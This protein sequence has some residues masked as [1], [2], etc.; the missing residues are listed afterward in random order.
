MKKYLFTNNEWKQNFAYA[1]SIVARS[2]NEFISDAD[3]VFN[4]Y[5]EKIED[6]DYVSI[7]HNEKY[8]NRARAYMR[9]SF[10]NF[11]APL[12]TLANSVTRG[13]DS[14][15]RYGDH[16]EVVAYE[17]GCNVWYVTKAPEGSKKAHK[18]ESCG[19]LSFRLEAMKEFEMSVEVRDKKLVICVAGECF[20]ADAPNLS[21][22]FQFGFTACEGRNRIYEVGLE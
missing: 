3:H 14:R 5:N 12:I 17:G 4:D 20:E 21:E 2:F 13:D 11:G 15:L 1:Y 9:C 8:G 18:S 10:D 16:Y 22:D 6:Y 19:C 7:V